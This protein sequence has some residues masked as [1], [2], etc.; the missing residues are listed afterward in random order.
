M[1]AA[2]A[3]YPRAVTD[4]GVHYINHS[5]IFTYMMNVFWFFAWCLHRYINFPPVRSHASM[6]SCCGTLNQISSQVFFP[7]YFAGFRTL[8]PLLCWHPLNCHTKLRIPWAQKPSCTAV[9]P[10]KCSILNCNHKFQMK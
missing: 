10:W 4:H 6:N 3:P 9:S 1:Q 7:T 2:E 5:S 8:R